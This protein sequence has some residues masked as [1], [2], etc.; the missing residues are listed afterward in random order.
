MIDD[1][2]FRAPFGLLG[3][4]VETLV[5]TRYM[6]GL[7]LERNSYIKQAAEAGTDSL[8]HV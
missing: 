2:K 8:P 7:L 1:F 5:L 3:R 6:K 4:A